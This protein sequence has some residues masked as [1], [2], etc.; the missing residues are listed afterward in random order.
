MFR[1]KTSPVQTASFDDSPCFSGRCS[2]AWEVG[3]INLISRSL[4]SNYSSCVFS[5]AAW[6]L[7]LLCLISASACEATRT[8]GTSRGR[9]VTDGIGRKVTLAAKVER[10]VSLAPSVTE[11]VFAAGGGDRLVGVTSYCN[12]PAEAA[13]IA[14][15]GDTMT[16]NMES[17]VALRPDLVI[18]SK[19]SQVESFV[20]T[21]SANGIEIYVSDP[22]GV[23]DVIAEIRRLGEIFGTEDTAQDTADKLR[24]RVG[25]V[26]NKLSG[27]GSRP[28]VL[29]QVSREPLF[30]IGEEA[31]LNEVVRQAG[32]VSATASV[33][34]AFPKLS[35][36][37]ALALMP[38]VIVLSDSEDNREP[39]DAFRSSP[40]V[41]NGRVYR[42]DA[43]ILSRPGP[44]TVDALERLASSL[45]PEIFEQGHDNK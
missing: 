31:F 27:V 17:I 44:R 18:V 29:V 41:R 13:S 23:I 43:D 12:Y 7:V 35:K 1:V 38:D 25:S 30:T 34:T 21:L 33:P 16:P 6:L 36:E 3:R 39:N 28:S 5:A 37:S 22:K 26:T 10:V 45:H 9:V 11:L 8:A 15:I 24:S 32:G 40:A 4:Y 19:A 20:K 42:I 2:D 14:K